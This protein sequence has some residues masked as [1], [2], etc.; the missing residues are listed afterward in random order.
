LERATK[1][2]YRL[3]IIATLLSTLSL[4]QIGQ[5]KY[6]H[7][8]AGV[9]SGYTGYKTVELPIATSFVVGFGKESLDYLQYGKFDS[10]DL[11]ATTLGGV[12]ISLTIKLINKNKDEKI[13]NRI[14]RSY[15][16]HERIQRRQK[17]RLLKKDI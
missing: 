7:F 14:V 10:K 17:R 8:G 3:V 13:N 5:D 12:A 11:I 2:T 16:K 9:V 15:R 6:Y 1:R 4:A